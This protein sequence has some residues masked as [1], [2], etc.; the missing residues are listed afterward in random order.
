MYVQ[1]QN[2]SAQVAKYGLAGVA[3]LMVKYWVG[4]KFEL[5]GSAEIEWATSYLLHK[6]LG[7]PPPEQAMSIG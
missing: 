4:Q 5:G 3:Q 1:D 7:P 2:V 6:I